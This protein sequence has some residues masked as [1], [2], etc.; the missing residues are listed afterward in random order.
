VVWC[1]MVVFHYICILC[2]RLIFVYTFSFYLFIHLLLIYF[3]IFIF[4]L[5]I[6]L[7][8]Y[9]KYVQGDQWKCVE[10]KVSSYYFVTNRPNK[11]N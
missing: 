3:Y 4:Y 10:S 2:G 11:M 7:F 1:G 8:I 9:C 5:F 6:Y